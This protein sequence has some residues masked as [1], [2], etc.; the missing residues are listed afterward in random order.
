MYL[1]AT[2]CLGGFVAVVLGN[3]RQA[4]HQGMQARQYYPYPF[5]FPPVASATSAS[6]DPSLL[7]QSALATGVTAGTLPGTASPTSSHVGNVSTTRTYSRTLSGGSTTTGLTSSSIGPL[8]TGYSSGFAPTSRNA[9]STSRVS[10]SLST[11][12][13]SSDPSASLGRGPYSFSSVSASA[14]IGTGTRIPRNVTSKSIPFKSGIFPTFTYSGLPG[15]F[16]G[17]SVGTGSIGTTASLSQAA[18]TV[19]NVTTPTYDPSGRLTLSINSSTSSPFGNATTAS[20]TTGPTGSGPSTTPLRGGYSPL[21]SFPILNGTAPSSV[22]FATDPFPTA[23][24]GGFLTGRY[25]FPT[26]STGGFLT[27]RS[28]FPTLHPPTYSTGISILGTG[29]IG[30]SPGVSQAATTTKGPS[31]TPTIS[32]NSTVSL[33]SESATIA[34]STYFS[35]PTVASALS[36]P[37]YSTYGDPSASSVT[38]PSILSASIYPGTISPTP[39]TL[40][41]STSANDFG[42]EP[43]TATWG[44]YDYRKHRYHQDKNRYGET[45]ANRAYGPNYENYIYARDHD[46]GGYAG[47][48]YAFE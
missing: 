6:V 23:S 12:A 42:F 32:A 10:V 35:G 46:D 5:S 33:L 27:G 13:N 1:S 4:V 14:I 16:V 38:T 36:T 21:P 43:S 3:P 37:V 39:T 31:T 25:P 24:T 2:F 30:T 45:A 41:T 17:S 44:G 47:R 7:S 15:S 20:F 28:P 26:A 40:A 11:T 29:T 48:N 19:A 18:T 8:S 22:P 9:S 34:N